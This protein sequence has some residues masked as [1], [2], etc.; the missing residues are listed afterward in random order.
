MGT[1][2]MYRRMAAQQTE[3]FF[4]N[5]KLSSTLRMAKTST[6]AALAG[7]KK[8]FASKFNTLVSTVTANDKKYE[9]GL[10]HITGVAHDWKNKDA[11]ARLLLLLRLLLLR[12]RFFF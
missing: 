6:A 4:K 7:A 8:E 10:K 1:Q 3:Q 12:L 11:A 9:A 2:K 5:Q